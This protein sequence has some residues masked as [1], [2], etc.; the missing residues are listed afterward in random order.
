MS[1]ICR[2]LGVSGVPLTAARDP[3]SEGA[4]RMALETEHGT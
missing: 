2:A 4:A 1:S 3:A